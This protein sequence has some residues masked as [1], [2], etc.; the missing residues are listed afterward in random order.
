MGLLQQV[1]VEPGGH[2]DLSAYGHAWHTNCSSEPHSPPLDDDCVTPLPDSWDLLQIGVDPYGG[3][4]PHGS[5]VIWS[6]PVEQYGMYGAPVKLTGVEAVSGV[7]T[8]FLRSECNYPLRHNDVYWD[9]VQVE[10]VERVHLPL[11][12]AR[13]GRYLL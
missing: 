5:T 2:F 8:V 3:L 4:D 12:I 11:I 6:T 1:N 7:M 13:S 9:D 10:R